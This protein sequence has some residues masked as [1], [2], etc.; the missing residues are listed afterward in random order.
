MLDV[1]SGIV[2]TFRHR[3]LNIRRVLEFSEVTKGGEANTIFRWDL[4]SDKMKNVGKMTTPHQYA[5]LYAGMDE[6]EIQKDIEEKMGVL[7]WM[8]KKDYYEVDQVGELVSNYYLNQENLLDAVR[9][10]KQ[11]D[12]RVQIVKQR[13]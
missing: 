12:F 6:K 3:R 1:L 7:D 8:V 11:W 5:K 4:K 10:G 2:V 13:L 9:K